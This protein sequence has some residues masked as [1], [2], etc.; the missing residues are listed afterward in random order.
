MALRW[1]ISEL[2]AEHFDRAYALLQLLDEGRS[3][4]DWKTE[5]ESWR[6]HESGLQAGVACISDQRDYVMSLC[7]YTVRDG[8]VCGRALEIDRVVMPDTLAPS[9]SH[10]LADLFDGFAREKNCDA[11]HISTADDS[12]AVPGTTDNV[13]S[14]ALESD[15]HF[16]VSHW[17]RRL[18]EKPA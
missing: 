16:S 6:A 4:D 15:F 14:A 7:F 8:T 17:C 3:C 5:I 18:T 10:N 1:N 13:I 11:I 2:D 9:V 12:G